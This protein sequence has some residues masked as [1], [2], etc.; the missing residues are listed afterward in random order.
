[1]FFLVPLQIV[2]G[3]LLWDLERFQPIIE[4]LGGVRVVDAFHIII[5][6]I[7]TAFLIAHIY[8]ATLG[9]TFFAHYKAMIVGYEEKEGRYKKIPS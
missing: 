2:T 6:Y 1:M 7:V 9:H 5:A 3:V 8:L 4:A